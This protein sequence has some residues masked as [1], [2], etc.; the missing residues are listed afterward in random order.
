[1][2]AVAV[3]VAAVAVVVGDGELD[4]APD[5]SRHSLARVVDTVVA[6]NRSGL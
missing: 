3:V 2:A 4:K 5:D 1:M 6:Q